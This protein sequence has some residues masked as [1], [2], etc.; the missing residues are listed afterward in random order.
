[1]LWDSLV[2]LKAIHNLLIQIKVIAIIPV[3]PVIVVVVQP[4]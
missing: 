1:M 2:V 4:S 3:A